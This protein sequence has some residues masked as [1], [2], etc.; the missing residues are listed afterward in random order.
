MRVAGESCQH[1]GF[2]PQRPP[3]SIVFRDGDLAMVDRARRTAEGLPDPA[4]RMRWHGMLTHIAN[5]RGYKPGWVAHKFKEKFGAWPAA[6]AVMPIEPSREVL[7]WVRS[8][9]I[10]W[11]KA[12]EKINRT[13]A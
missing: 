12:Q 4:E 7:S 2:L 10:A 13:A 8:R 1:C 11:A 6:R 3:K 9:N 5:D